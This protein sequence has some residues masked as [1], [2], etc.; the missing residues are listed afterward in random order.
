MNRSSL[1]IKNEFEA[2]R[3]A[4][5]AMLMTISFAILVYVLNVLKIFTTPLATMTMAMSLVTLCLIIPAVLVFLFKKQGRWVKYVIVTSAVVMV[6]ILS[7]FLTYHAVL[8]YIYAIAIASLY[9]SKKLSWFAVGLS[10]AFLSVSQV[11]GYYVGVTV[12][13]NFID[14]YE[15]IL[16]GIAPRGIELV[17]VSLIF[18]ALATRAANLLNSMMGA[19]EQ[20]ELLDRMV[21]LSDKS[22]EVST[23][24]SDSVKQLTE[25]T[26]SSSETSEQIA[27]SANKVA[28]GSD[29][30]I[31]KVDTA[32]EV[33]VQMSDKL[34]SIADQ[35]KQIA[36]FSSKVNELAEKNSVVMRNAANKMEVID[37]VTSESRSIVSRLS[38]RS[39]EISS[40]ISVITGISEQTNLLALNAAIESARAGELGKGFAVVANE[41]RKLA[42]QS[43]SAAE[44]ISK[45]IEEVLQ[46]TQNAVS[47]MNK[48]SSMVAE[49]LTVIK[50]ADQSYQNISDSIKGMSSKIA[51][52]SSFSSDVAQRGHQLTEII[53]DI[54]EINHRS[55]VD[56][57]NIA[58]ASEEQLA[59][60][61]QV[62]SSVYSIDNIASELLSLVNK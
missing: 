45:L 43:K 53:N 29:Y 34:D 22:K 31:Q 32:A 24:L 9:F 40:I 49:G 50:E 46:G 38:E 2:N 59:S 33:V 7:I 30:T 27:T 8:M 12:D 14:L 20:K 48:S 42:E 47:A 11:I 56:L 36:S 41:V 1:L 52:V 13:E 10:V 54:K 18:I 26:E 3:F 5:K 21:A 61:Q 16:F 44:K 17:A 35:N 4:A 19:E 28:D 37:E 57:Q 39:N 23:V 25:I 6:S 60:M 51:D 15:V 62:T 58:S 55:I